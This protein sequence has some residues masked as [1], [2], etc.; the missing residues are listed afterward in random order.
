[1]PSRHPTVVDALALQWRRDNRSLL[2]E[3]GVPDEA[4]DSDR[5]WLYLLLHGNDYPGTGWDA[6]WVAPAQ[7]ARLLGKLVADLPGESG[8]DL[9]RSL[10]RRSSSA[11]AS[12]CAVDSSS[13]VEG[14]GTG[15]EG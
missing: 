5:R 9:V 14:P 3:C 12:P 2:S 11:D 13:G 4:A 6:T 10:R 8:Y 7:A 1:M 15:R